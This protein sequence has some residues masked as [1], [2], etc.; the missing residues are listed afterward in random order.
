MEDAHRCST[1]SDLSDSEPFQESGSEFVPF[2]EE[3]A[4][5]PS[6][7]D[8]PKA[9]RDVKSRKRV[10]NEKKWRRS[11]AKK[12]RCA[13]EE[14]TTRSNRVVPAKTFSPCVC[15]CKHHYKNM[16]PEKRQRA[17]HQYFYSL[18]NFDFQTAHLF[19][20]I[21]VEN[22][23]RTYTGNLQSRREKT[24]IFLLPDKNDAERK[25]CKTFFLS[26][27]SGYS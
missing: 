8:P 11:V 1:S 20:L 24:R 19:S 23:L 27:I 13:G 6:V 9:S 2:D 18:E 17:L 7:T 14:Y 10:R 25:V 5:E 16:I 22:K 21:K 3:S 4:D 26:C 15:S 12:K